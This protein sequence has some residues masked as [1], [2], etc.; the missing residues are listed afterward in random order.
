M[1]FLNLLTFCIDKQL[2]V[3]DNNFIFL[4]NHG[5][6]IAIK[7]EKNISKY[8]SYF[9]TNIL[10]KSVKTLAKINGNNGFINIL[11]KIGV[12]SL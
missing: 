4:T 9:S 6:D 7:Y 8:P 5:D 10:M 2:I 3:F 12:Q 11:E 1:Q